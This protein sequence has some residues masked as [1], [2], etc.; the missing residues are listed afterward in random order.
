MRYLKIENSYE[1]SAEESGLLQVKKDSRQEEMT[2][3]REN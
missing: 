3:R 1:E 2:T